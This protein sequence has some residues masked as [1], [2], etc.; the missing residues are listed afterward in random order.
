MTCA[1]GLTQMYLL[2]LIQLHRTGDNLVSSLV[3]FYEPLYALWTI[4]SE[5]VRW[6]RAL[7]VL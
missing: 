6:E 2:I 1:S 5:M 4:L 3:Q 7:L